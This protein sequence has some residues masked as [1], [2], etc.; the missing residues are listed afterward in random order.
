MI[1]LSDNSI[2]D[3]SVYYAK[4]FYNAYIALEQIHNN[5]IDKMLYRIPMLVNGALSIELTLKAILLKNS[6]TYNKEH[7]L[8]NLFR[9]IPDIF[10]TELLSHLFEK[11]PEYHDTHKLSEELI[12]V[13]D[14]FV[15]WRYAFEDRNAPAVDARFISAF[16][17][18]AIWT[19][20]SHYNVNLIESDEKERTDDEIEELYKKNREQNVERI[21]KKISL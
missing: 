3:F 15:D 13:S 4:S 5:S 9:L 12:L 11:A 19:M 10:Q 8:L 21:I 1:S 14:A 7:N 17:N 6:I 20:L 18:A 16:A 2:A